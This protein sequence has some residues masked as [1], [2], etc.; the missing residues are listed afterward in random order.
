MSVDLSKR[1]NILIK[2]CQCNSWSKLLSL[3]SVSAI[4]DT[5]QQKMSSLIYFS[6]ENK[7]T[8]MSLDSSCS[9]QGKC[10]LVLI[11]YEIIKSALKQ[12]QNI[13][14]WYECVEF[15]ECLQCIL[16]VG[17][18][19]FCLTAILIFSAPATLI[20]LALFTLP[21]CLSIICNSQHC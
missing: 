3:H 20:K 17:S 13:S 6:T 9:L 12:Q 16:S 4:S 1:H 11:E 2:H 18:M 14:A 19:L 8:C 5:D 10:I 21:D 15:Y 7:I